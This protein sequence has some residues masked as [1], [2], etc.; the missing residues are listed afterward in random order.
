MPS[1]SN[2]TH[3]MQTATTDEGM[4]LKDFTLFHA[5]NENGALA[6]KLE[7]NRAIN[8]AI[9]DGAMQGGAYWAY[10][11]MNNYHEDRLIKQAMRKSPNK[12]KARYYV[13]C[14]KDAAK[15]AHTKIAEA[16]SEMEAA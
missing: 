7:S 15:K 9:E 4:C 13:Q 6:M 5:F 14:L 3:A 12:Y 10:G 16:Y 8:K 1:K 11:A 2:P